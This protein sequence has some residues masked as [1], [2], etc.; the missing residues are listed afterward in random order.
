MLATGVGS[1]PGEDPVEAARIVAGELPELPHLPE[2]PARGPWADITGRGIALLVDLA[3]EYSVGRWSLTPRPGRDARRAQSALA[4][5]LDAVEEVF[6]AEQQTIKLQ[7]CGP[8]TLSATTELRSGERAVADAGARRDL[9]DS[10]AEGVGVHLREVR[11][12]FPAAGRLLLAMDEPALSQVVTGA[13]PSASGYRNLAAVPSAEVVSLLGVVTDAIS[14]EGAQSV[15]H[16]CADPVP[17]DLLTDVSCDYLSF[18]VDQLGGAFEALDTLGRWFDSGG[19]LIAGLPGHDSEVDAAQ[20]RRLMHDTGT[21]V[22]RN[23]E[24]WVVSPTCGLAGS[25]PTEVVAIYRRMQEIGR[26][27][28]RLAGVE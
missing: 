14:D 13:L 16:S 11:R 4:R 6:G 7:V 23:A 26:Q 12:R 9:A 1:M 28:S 8:V 17:L 25:S 2:L 20:L 27:M 10:L 15:L 5:D 19:G 21:S 18:P 3:A 22:E 24:Q